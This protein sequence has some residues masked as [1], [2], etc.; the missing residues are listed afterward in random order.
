ML[1]FSGKEI[2]IKDISVDTA[3]NPNDI[4]S[5]FQAL[6][7]L[8]YW[9]GRHL[10]LKRQVR[11][12]LGYMRSIC[13]RLVCEKTPVDQY[14]QIRLFSFHVRICSTNSKKNKRKGR[15]ALTISIQRAS[16][17]LLTIITPPPTTTNLDL[18]RYVTLR[19]TSFVFQF[20]F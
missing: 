12:Q 11:C 2:S 4:V 8:K 18:I 14:F 5:T 17:G 15:Q 1:C 20:F 6:G 19:L 9:K 7:M 3:I 16:N 10:V 13:F